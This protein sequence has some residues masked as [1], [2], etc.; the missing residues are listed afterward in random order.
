MSKH[1]SRIVMPLVIA[2]SACL[3]ASC[4]P[5]DAPVAAAPK[6]CAH[7]LPEGK[8]PFCDRSLIE[9]LGPCAEHDVPEALCWICS[10]RLVEVFK[11]LNDWCGG[12]DRPESLCY[13]CNPELEPAPRAATSRPG[14]STPAPEGAA[15][16]ALPR[17]RRPPSVSCSTSQTRV[18]LASLE[19]ARN[20][21]LEVQAVRREPVSRTLECNAEIAYNGNHFARITSRVPG[22][23]HEV[24]RDVGARVAAGDVLAIVDSA[25][26]ASAKAEYLQATGTVA[27]WEKTHQRAH[28]LGAQG[29]IPRKDDFE[30]E[31]R[32]AESRVG[33]ARVGQR[34]R[35]LGL[36]PDQV[37]EVAERQDTS[38]LLAL[39]APFAGQIVERSAVIGETVDTTRTLFAVADTA[40]MWAHLDIYEA[41]ISQVRAGQPVVVTIDGLP[42]ESFGGRI[43]WLSTQVDARTRTLRA[44]VELPNPEGLLRSNMFG[45]AVVTVYDRQPLLVVP[46]AAVQWD[47]CCNI[48]FVRRGDL[49]YEP[50]KLRL[51]GDAGHHF[52]VT[53]GLAEGDEVVTQGSFLLKTEIM[54]SSIGA[55]CCEADGRKG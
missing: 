50:R 33:L 12:H 16:E 7:S 15:A 8:C 31:T 51:G 26:L 53:E 29:I 42:G 37:A 4:K 25:E 52:V 11:A 32:L 19:I 46:R 34:L 54:K 24:A 20:V 44:R 22:V 18:R 17:S 39:A 21:G 5:A 9:R 35:T 48:A 13:I 45:R 3:P 23:V 41:D 40:I 38:P 2:A 1:A 14:D 10:P 30:A 27:L 55:G 43:T 6:A 36:T 47:G 49:L 28:E